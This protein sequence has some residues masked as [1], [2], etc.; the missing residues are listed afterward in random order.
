MAKAGAKSKYESCVKPYLKEINEKVRQGV[1]EADIAKSLGIS[2]AS[3]N[4]Y[5]NQYAELREAL[6]KDKGADVLQDLI[7]AGIRA[8]TGY[9]EE[10]VKTTILLDDS[11]KPL[12][13]QREINKIWYPPNPV[14]NRF[15]VS[16]FGKDQGFT[17]DPLEYELRKA[18]QELDAAERKEKNWDMYLDEE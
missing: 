11:G 17:S 13:K 1:V 6:S 9:F 12:K 5:K 7:N 10:N 8:A 15:Y 4:N 3:L 16:N 14:L 18:K 2:V